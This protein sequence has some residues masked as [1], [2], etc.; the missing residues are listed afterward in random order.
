MASAIRTD[1]VATVVTLL[2]NN[3]LEKF[4]KGGGGGGEDLVR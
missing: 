4:S 3:T 2:F 1:A